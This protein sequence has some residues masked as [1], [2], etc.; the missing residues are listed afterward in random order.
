MHDYTVRKY[1][2]GDKNGQWVSMFANENGFLSIEYP[3]EEELVYME[4]IHY[5]LTEEDK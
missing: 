3:S 5:T 2:Y 1:H 4:I